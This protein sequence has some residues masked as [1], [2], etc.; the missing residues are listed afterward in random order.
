MVGCY[1]LTIFVY[2]SNLFNGLSERIEME[3]KYVISDKMLVC[4]RVEGELFRMFGISDGM[5]Q[6]DGLSILLFDFRVREGSER[7]PSG[8][9]GNQSD[10]NVHQTIFSNMFSRWVVFS[11]MDDVIACLSNCIHISTNQRKPRQ[12]Q[13][14]RMYR[15]ASHDIKWTFHF[16]TVPR[17][18]A[19]FY[20][21][22]SNSKDVRHSM[23]STIEICVEST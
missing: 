21:I 8:Q 15:I 17:A 16:P 3:V 12:I 4:V 18:P 22:S 13:T 6:G 11:N 23:S 10:F 2:F 5:R 7:G 14:H 1:I 9:P 20:R 19:V